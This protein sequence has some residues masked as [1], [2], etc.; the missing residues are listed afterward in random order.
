MHANGR[1]PQFARKGDW[2]DE[3]D[4]ADLRK[5]KSGKCDKK[6]MR[7]RNPEIQESVRYYQTN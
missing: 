7:Q 3:N 2:R 5:I 4:Q 1:P 6:K